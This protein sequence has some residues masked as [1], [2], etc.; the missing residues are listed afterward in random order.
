MPF[1]AFMP[2]VILA[3]LLEGFMDLIAFVTVVVLLALC[4]AFMASMGLVRLHVQTRHPR[5]KWRWR[6]R[7]SF[8]SRQVVWSA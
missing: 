2:V 8:L 3:G 1:I 7:L 6:H 4:E 5:G